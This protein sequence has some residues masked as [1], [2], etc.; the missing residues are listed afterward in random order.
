MTATA[1]PRSYCTPSNTLPNCLDSAPALPVTVPSSPI[2]RS[3]QLLRSLYH[4]SPSCSSH[5]SPCPAQ[6]SSRT[7]D[8]A[9][10]STEATRASADDNLHNDSHSSYSPLLQSPQPPSIKLYG[11]ASDISDDAGTQRTSVAMHSSTTAGAGTASANAS[12]R[13]S[14]EAPQRGGA[15]V[16]HE[17]AALAAACAGDPLAAAGP[18][19][20]ATAQG[21]PSSSTARDAAAATGFTLGLSSPHSA[22]REMGERTRCTGGSVPSYDPHFNKVRHVRARAMKRKGGDATDASSL[23]V[24][25]QVRCTE[26]VRGPPGSSGY[27]TLKST[28]NAVGNEGVPEGSINFSPD[29]HAYNSGGFFSPSPASTPPTLVEL[30]LRRVRTTSL[31]QFLWVLVLIVMLLVGNAGQVIFLNFWIH[32]FPVK[33]NAPS[34]PSCSGSSSSSSSGRAEALESSYTTFIISAILFSIFFVVLFCVYALVRRPNLKFAREGAGWWLL[35][36]IGAM[37]TLNSAMAIYAAAHTPE[38]LQALFVSLVPVYSAFFTKWLLKDP[39]NYANAYVAVSFALIMAGVALA[40]L[41]SYAAA[42]HDSQS[43][44]S[45]DTF[46]AG[47]SS[48]GFVVKHTPAFLFNLLT[49]GAPTSAETRDKQIW[50]LIFFFSVPPT[51]LLNVLQTMYMIRYTYTDDMTAYLMAHGGEAEISALRTSIASNE[52]PRVA[53]EGAPRAVDAEERRG[54]EERAVRYGGADPRVCVCE[55]PPREGGG[56]AASTAAAAVAAAVQAPNST[57]ASSHSSGC[58]DSDEGGSPTP[59]EHRLHVPFS[60]L[61]LHGEDTTVKLVMLAADTTIQALMALFLMPMDALPWFGGSD[62]IQEVWQNLDEGVDCVL[63]CPHNMRY[64]LL[65]SA[66]FVLVYIAAAYLNRYSVTLCSMVSQLSGPV[67][68]LVLIVFPSLNITGDAA[69]WYISVFAVVLLALGTAIYVYWDEMTS[70]E[71]ERGEMQLKWSMMEKQAWRQRP[72]DDVGDDRPHSS[73][74]TTASVLDTGLTSDRD[75]QQ[76]TQQQQHRHRRSRTRRYRRR[77]QSSY[78]VVVDHD[79]DVPRDHHIPPAAP[80]Q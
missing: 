62:S 36:G 18:K 4:H 24:P 26:H 45:Q 14:E 51:V 60:E 79:P 21:H 52:N 50:C 57:P 80:S 48:H 11:T 6:P 44:G 53:V 61:R 68:A 3:P 16:Q 10:L 2:P 59:H 42:H 25:G 46:A 40:S 35:M 65:Y 47:S 15:C 71:K 67:T 13:S 1:P 77:R 72:T 58:T 7:A 29:E 28:D 30:I 63:H 32:Q 64:C 27:T 37:D 20:A 74:A 76:Q 55:P 43:D 73:S 54:G 75:Q 66:G 17:T 12:P 23:A 38:V 41:F 70:E 9:L 33:R 22:R 8:T 78:V 34:A 49:A 5:T 19:S 39:R 69:P 56:D 31:F